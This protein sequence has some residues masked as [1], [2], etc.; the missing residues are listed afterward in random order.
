MWS[1]SLIPSTAPSTSLR[2]I[3]SPAK[4]SEDQM[5][6]VR[7]LQIDLPGAGFRIYWSHS[8]G[9]T[10][11]ELICNARTSNAQDAHFLIGFARHGFLEY[12][13]NRWRDELLLL[14][15]PAAILA[16]VSSHT[17]LTTHFRYV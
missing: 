7:S 1:K 10:Y 16:V 15:P 6:R 12:S 5:P 14:L 11:W 17:A 8:L 4:C 9:N 2:I 13:A 3:N